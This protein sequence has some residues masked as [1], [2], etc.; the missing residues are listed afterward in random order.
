MVSSLFSIITHQLPVFNPLLGTPDSLFPLLLVKVT[1]PV[2]FTCIQAVGEP[3]SVPHMSTLSKD[4]SQRLPLTTSLRCGKLV[5][6]V[7]SFEVIVA[8]YLFLRG[9]FT[10]SVFLGLPDRPGSTSGAQISFRRGVACGCYIR[11]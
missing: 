9:V 7:K 11:P 5:A 3:Y 10:L 4:D 8:Y 1:N 6:A 2:W